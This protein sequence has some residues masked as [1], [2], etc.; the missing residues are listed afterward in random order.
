MIERQTRAPADEPPEDANARPVAA[1][2]GVAAQ[3]SLVYYNMFTYRMVM[4]VLYRGTYRARFRRIIDVM[5]PNVRSVCDLC[6]GDTYIAEW[7]RAHGVQWTG[8]EINHYF[9]ERARRRGFDVREGDLLAI[10]LPHAD[11][12]VMAA[13]LYHFHSDLPALLDRVFSR[14]PRFIISEPVRNVSRGRLGAWAKYVANPGTGDATFRYDE[15]SLLGALRTQQARQE[16]PF[17]VVSVHRD[18]LI[19]VRR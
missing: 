2:P 6:F 10:D 1:G 15:D 19:E 12:F 17:R 14:S 4:H 8:V 13:A 11:V 16:L 9:C 18:M 7:C 3:R 5:G